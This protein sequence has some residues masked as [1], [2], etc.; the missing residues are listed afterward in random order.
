MIDEMVTF[1]K[2]EAPKIQ[3]VTLIACFRSYANFSSEVIDLSLD[4]RKATVKK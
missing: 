4:F 2:S 3:H 1:L